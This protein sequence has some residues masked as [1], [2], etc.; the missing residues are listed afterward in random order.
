MSTIATRTW[1]AGPA[2]GT[3]QPRGDVIVVAW[4]AVL[5]LSLLAR[6]MLDTRGLGWAWFIHAL[7]DVAI[8]GFM[9]IGEITPGGA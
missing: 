5:A 1:D 4:V 2:M 3:A 7:Q 6:S 8:F 9:A